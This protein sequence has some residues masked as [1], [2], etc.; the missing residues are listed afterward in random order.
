MRCSPCRDCSI[1]VERSASQIQWWTRARSFAGRIGARITRRP[2]LVCPDCALELRRAKLYRELRV[3]DSC[4]H[5]FPL[6]A[7]KRIG[8][9]ADAHS[10]VELEKHLATRGAVGAYAKRVQAAERETRLRE[11]VVIG[12]ARIRGVEVVL[13]VLDFRFLGGSMGAV[14]GEKIARA[15]ESATEKKLPL[16]AV[17]TSGGARIQEGM[18][19]L[20]Q[21]AKTAAVAQ[22]YHQIGKPFITVLAHPTTGG[23]YASFAN[24]ADVILA[25]PR[26]LIGFAGPRVVEILTRQQLPSDSHRAEFLLEHGMVDAIIARPQLRSTIGEM[27]EMLDS[28]RLPSPP[29]PLPIQREVDGFS[30]WQSVILARHPDRPTTLDYIRRIFG[31]FTELHGDRLYGDDPAMVAGIAGL[32]GQAV[33]VVGQE[34]GHGAE[35]DRRRHGSAG[36]EG[37]RKAQRIMQLAAKW[38]LPVI[39]FVDTPGADASY[40]AEKRGVAPALARTIATMLN[41]RVPTL[42]VVIGEGGSGGALALAV[43]DRV[44]M[45]EHSVYSVISPEGASAILYGDA[46]HAEELSPELHLTAH[47]LREFGIIDETIMEPEGG[48][49]AAPD[50]M[51]TRVRA[52][53]LRALADLGGKSP[54]DLLQARY[55]KYRGIGKTE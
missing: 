53:L 30:P 28:Q 12:T 22:R 20:L 16:L 35:S 29:P 40:E 50:E 11:A 41:L 8:S 31:N 1:R 36:P 52:H 2:R 33:V 25:E 9:L 54:E 39:T 26:A 15:F 18:L 45:L 24:L 43:A 21:M 5:H 13:V 17:T 14:A 34:R 27:L 10:F 7:R 47:D 3:C 4:G 37:Y 55:Q 32:D 23:V 51:A 44:L 19:A 46:S 38:N 49:H 42:A 6:D 48:A